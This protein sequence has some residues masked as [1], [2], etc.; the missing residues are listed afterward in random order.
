VKRLHGRTVAGGT[1]WG[2]DG[3]E[4]MNK[5]AGRKGR[6]TG[7]GARDALNQ[8]NTG[9]ETSAP[10]R[11]SPST[12]A[13]VR[14]KPAVRHRSADCTVTTPL[15]FMAMHCAAGA[16]DT[17]KEVGSF[18]SATQGLEHALQGLPALQNSEGQM[19]ATQGAVDD[20]W[21]EPA[22][23]SLGTIDPAAM[24]VDPLAMHQ[25]FRVVNP[26]LLKPQGALQLDHA[27]VWVG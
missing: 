14:T 19:S 13:A 21:E 2:R 1:C 3:D 15:A 22:H 20:G 12:T 16:I 10:P 26:T 18:T 4:R 9:D 11:T 24:V 17:P 27:V 6:G 25:T 5:V 23:Q 8:V 7:H